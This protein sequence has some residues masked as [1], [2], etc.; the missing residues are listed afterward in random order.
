MSVIAQLFYLL[1]QGENRYQKSLQKPQYCCGRLYSC[2]DTK[3][4][5]STN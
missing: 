4:K 3:S 5:A 2:P 1:I